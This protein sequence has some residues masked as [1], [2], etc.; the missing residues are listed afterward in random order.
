M[1]DVA[2]ENSATTP[3]GTRSSFSTFTI[4]NSA[5]F[6][7]ALLDF[8]AEYANKL[9][10]L[11]TMNLIFQPLWTRPRVRSFAYG[12][13][14]VLGLENEKRD[15]VVVLIHTTWGDPARSNEIK[16]SMEKFI[17]QAQEL[18][19]KMDVYHPYLYLNYAES[20]QDVM[21]SYGPESMS[22]MLNTSQKYD[23]IQL[24]QKR[25]PGGFKLRRRETSEVLKEPP[26]EKHPPEVTKEP[27]TEKH[28]PEV[29]KE[30]PTEKR[31]PTNP[32]DQYQPIAP[33]DQY[34]P[35]YPYDQYQPIAQGDQ[36]P[37]TYPYDQ[38][39]QITPGYGYPPTYPYDQYQPIAPGYGYP[40]TDPYG[41]YQ[42]LS[43]WNQY[44]PTYPYNQ[45]QPTAPGY[46]YP[47]TEPYGQ[48]PPMSP[49]SQYPPMSPYG[50]YPTNG[51]SSQYPSTAPSD[52]QPSSGVPVSQLSPLS[53]SINQ[54]TASSP[55][56]QSSPSSAPANKLSP[57]GSPIA[58][59]PPRAYPP[60][61]PYPPPA[62]PYQMVGQS[63]SIG[64]YPLGY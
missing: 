64:L 41:Q 28:P 17:R 8:G 11:S 36:Y 43:Q 4:I 19:R 46:R 1:Q 57:S 62:A 7:D 32:Y 63:P 42:P 49:Y 27:P 58:Q 23:P 26:T 35:T 47:P 48:A 18:A 12:G 15:L 25:V 44:P 54:P 55:V 56:G 34:P 6:M 39:Q 29:T 40:P 61:V 52:Q 45:Y 5:K 24:W 16:Q 2:R 13:G 50:Q 37:P 53:A 38:Y 21:S 22:F 9:P 20:F 51:P 30:P 14:N 59:V 31:P 3:S 10:T 60:A 33:G